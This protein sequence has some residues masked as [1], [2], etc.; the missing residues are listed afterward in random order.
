LNVGQGGEFLHWRTWLTAR[1]VTA[2]VLA[3]VA[4]SVSLVWM[5]MLGEKLK[6]RRGPRGEVVRAE[7]DAAVVVQLVVGALLMAVVGGLMVNRLS[8]KFAESAVASPNLLA[9][10]FAVLLVSANLAVVFVHADDG[11]LHTERLETLSRAVRR[12]EGGQRKAADRTDRQRERVRRDVVRIRS[13]AV[14][15]LTTAQREIS[16]TGTAGQLAGFAGLPAPRAAGHVEGVPICP[17]GT[18]SPTSV[19]T[20]ALAAVLIQVGLIEERMLAITS[21]APDA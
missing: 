16:A 9:A 4:A 20:C 18:H 2:I 17:E 5:S 21:R 10:L 7:L 15:A 14:E 8:A 3:A 1:G 12:R 13:I 6:A 19:C 11:S